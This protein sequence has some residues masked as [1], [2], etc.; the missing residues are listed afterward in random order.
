MPAVR[1]AA[2]ARSSDDKQEASCPQ[3]HE[4]A[5]RKAAALGAELATYHED[6]GIPG[7]RLDRP[8]LEALFADLQRHQ[9]ARQPVPV[10]LVFD[11]DRLSR[12]TSWATGAIMERLMR[13]GVERLITATE[14]VDLYDDGDRAIYGLKQD[15]TK[16]GYAKALSK[17]IAR[18]MPQYA[19]AGC[20]TGGMAPHGYRIAGEARHRRLVPGPQEEVAVVRELF[21]LAAEGALSALAL[22]RLANERGW[23]VPAASARQQ[24][25]EGPGCV[26]AWTDGAVLS[27]LRNPAY[28]GAIRYGRRR[29]GKYH[30]ATADGPVEKRGPGQE[31]APALLKEGCHEPLIDRAT[32]DRVQ[33]VLCS[34][35]VKSPVRDAD[36]GTVRQRERRRNRKR[37]GTRHPEQFLFRGK[38]AC[39]CCGQPMQGCNEDEFHGYVCGSWRNDRACSRNGV[40]EADLLDRV[41]NL[42]AGELDN[43][44]TLNRLRRRLEAKRTG[45]GETLRLAVGKGRE[46]VGELQK[47]VEAGGR[48]LLSVSADLLPVAEKEYRRLKAELDT[49]QA[50]LAEVERQ[51]AATRAEE[52]NVEELLKRLSALP[53]LL[54]NADP[55]NRARVVRLAVANIRMRFEVNVGP[56][57][58]KW[59]RWTGATVTLTGNGPSYEIDVPPGTAGRGGPGTRGRRRGSTGAGRP[60]PSPAR[61]RR[62]RRTGPARPIAPPPPHP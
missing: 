34:R 47:Q 36:P 21:R 57:G 18:A 10:L 62:R 7:D 1:A 3:Q 45:Q 44:A 28:V 19:A 42:L 58:R 35:R 26:P 60:G 27:I 22:A 56:K 61:R 54:K 37:K 53:K 6:D 40:H 59:S 14:E 33:A 15:L 11:Q 38:L 30:Q 31:K 32:F 5:V 52:V 41:A 16:R 4:W 49:A 25:A 20:W 50:E 46:H 24:L 13:L 55:E 39:A 43:P 17:N 8:G 2:Y 48:R 51:A 9:K 12:A 23:P 29:K